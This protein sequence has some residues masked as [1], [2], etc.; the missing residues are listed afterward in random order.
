VAHD[1]LKIASTLN[2]LPYADTGHIGSGILIPNQDTRRRR[3]DE[4]FRQEALRLWRSSGRSAESVAKQ[5]DISVTNLYYWAR[6]RRAVS[7]EGVAP[8]INVATL[9]AENDWLRAEIEKLEHQK[10]ILRRALGIMSENLKPAPE[11]LAVG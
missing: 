11:T 5:L 10:Q 1:K 6:D 2:Q 3:Y 9:K 8:S 4:P 7:G